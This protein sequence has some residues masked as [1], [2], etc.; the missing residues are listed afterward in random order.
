MKKVIVLGA[1][2]VGRAMAKD[3]AHKYEV[4][5]V[6]I[7]K[8][9]LNFLKSSSRVN[10]IKGD[11]SDQ[12]LI[13]TL[14][15]D[16]DIVLSAVPGFMG[17]ETLKTIISCGKNLVDISFLPEDLLSL[18]D[19]AVK[20]KVSAIVDCGVAPGVPNLALGYY[21][22][23][24]KITDFEYMVGGLPKERNFPFEYKAPFSPVDVI[25]EYTRPA[26]YVQNSRMITK[27]AM[28]DPELV[29]FPGIGDLE[30][31]NTD[32]LRSLIF[33]MKHIPNM[34][35]KTLRYPGHI[36]LIQAFK[37]AGFFDNNPVK[38]NGTS[39]KPIDFT[40]NLLFRSWHLKPEE[41]EFTVMRIKITGKEGK[42]NKE[43][44]YDLYDKYDSESETSSMA[45]T[46]GYT[47]TA[48]V[49]LMLSG[50]FNKKGVF[51]PELVGSNPDHFNH[52]INYLNKRNVIYYRSE[53]EL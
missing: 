30:A 32:G 12:K 31:F 52:F 23:K 37:A 29:H 10:T 11:L 36:R 38:I 17:Y 1:G 35:E 44:I 51:P 33:T 19:I 47:A 34:K 46:T 16:F 15:T 20:N 45:R 26:R 41:N 2:M 42:I 18:N 27:P 24:M 43:I 6:D 25:E 4:T 40:T 14:I 49:D 48:A 7:N 21:N 53:R 9:A 39:V 50:K 22:E 3:L 13:K 5:S 8:E 28:S